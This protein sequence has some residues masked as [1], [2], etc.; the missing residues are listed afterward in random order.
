MHVARIHD[1]RSSLQCPGQKNQS[2]KLK[3]NKTMIPVCCFG[4]S[5]SLSLGRHVA[6][7]ESEMGQTSPKII[8]QKTATQ[9]KPNPRACVC[10]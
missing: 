10:V 7:F 9:D 1:Y 3:I 2:I 5:S 4:L 6:S 8:D